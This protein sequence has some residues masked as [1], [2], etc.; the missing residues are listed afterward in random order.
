MGLDL[1]EK[2]V[3]GYQIESQDHLNTNKENKTQRDEYLTSIPSTNRRR[4]SQDDQMSAGVASPGF[5][6][7]ARISDANIVQTEEIKHN[8]IN[9][10]SKSGSQIK[11]AMYQTMNAF[12]QIS[13]KAD[14][15][16]KLRNGSVSSEKRFKNY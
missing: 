10:N 1:Q 13:Q 6:P 16:K 4:E 9:S 8:S 12:D 2:Q 7:K 5:R 11:T 3:F 15:Q 14:S